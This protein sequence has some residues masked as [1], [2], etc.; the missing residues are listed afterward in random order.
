MYSILIEQ[1]LMTLSE[2]LAFH[3]GR[4]LSMLGWNLLHKL[5]NPREDSGCNLEMR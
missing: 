2:G 5:L 1:W 4:G 3:L